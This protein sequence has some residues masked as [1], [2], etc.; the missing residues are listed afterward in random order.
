MANDLMNLEDFQFGDFSN[1]PLLDLFDMDLVED[2][3]PR[4]DMSVEGSGSHQFGVMSDTVGAMSEDKPGCHS[5]TDTTNDEQGRPDGLA[6]L[7]MNDPAVL[8]DYMSLFLFTNNPS[9]HHLDLED[10]DSS[11]QV[12]IQALAAKLNLQYSHERS[13]GI[14]QL[15]KASYENTVGHN[16][17]QQPRAIPRS[18]ISFGFQVSSPSPQRKLGQITEQRGHFSSLDK[19][20][21]FSHNNS[22]MDIDIASYGVNSD[23]FDSWEDGNYSIATPQDPGLS[24]DE[25]DS[26]QA[27]GIPITSTP[28]RGWLGFSQTLKE[29]GA[30]WR[31]KILRK[32]C[33]PNQPCK[34]CPRPGANG[35]RWQGVGCK[36]GPLL[37]HVPHI[38]LCPKARGFGKID[39]DGATQRGGNTSGEDKIKK[40]L[41]DALNRLDDIFASDNDTYTKIILEIL[42]PPKAITIDTPPSLRHDVEGD[43]IHVAWGLVDITSAKDILQ[44]KSV[45]HTLDVLKAAITYETD[46][47][48]SH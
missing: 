12:I 32:K 4:A 1:G 10:C 16:E 5:I 11:R 48:L 47:N 39:L 42:C 7:D 27:K 26:S 2:G 6:Q 17:E 30:C 22:S 25:Q 24:E 37:D 28:R 36:R 46:R 14:I 18:D 33:D 43:A 19:V 21:S 20:T 35:S 8:S 31:C 34:A 15:R 23:N 13:R 41:E 38:S 40:C 3:S 45:E 9:V 44:L 29:V